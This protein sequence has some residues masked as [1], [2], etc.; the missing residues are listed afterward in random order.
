MVLKIK[1][2][3]RKGEF[4]EYKSSKR[5]L[6][7]RDIEEADRFDDKKNKVIEGLEKILLKKNF[8]RNNVTK[9]IP[10]ELGI[11]LGLN[12]INCLKVID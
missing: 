10:Y 3:N 1:G 5:I 2:R 8:F 9:E 7:S 12:L 6:T 4:V 11:L